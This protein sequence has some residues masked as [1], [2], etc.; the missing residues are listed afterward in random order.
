MMRA[1]CPTGCGRDVGEHKLLC[2]PCWREV[3]A[4]LQRAVNRTFRTWWS[5]RGNAQKFIDYD[6]ARQAAIGSIA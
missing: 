1:K 3:P 6:E 4:E 5:D 2:L